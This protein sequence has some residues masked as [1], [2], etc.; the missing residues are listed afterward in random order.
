MRNA[1]KTTQ[2][3]SSISCIHRRG[4]ASLTAESTCWDISSRY[5]LHT[6]VFVH[7]STQHIFIS[8]IQLLSFCCREGRLL[9]STETSAPSW[10]WGPSSGSPRKCLKI[11]EM[12]RLFTQICSG[13]KKTAPE[14]QLTDA[15]TFLS[16]CQ[17]MCSPTHRT[18]R[19]FWAST[20][21]SFHSPLSLS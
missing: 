3:T 1:M 7:Q 18:Q 14:L 12:V 6:C 19:V 13:R 9:P 2:Q 16:P 21:K 11:S 8:F 5:S 4:R 15:N 20:G 17:T 10:A